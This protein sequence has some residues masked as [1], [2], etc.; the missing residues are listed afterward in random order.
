[1]DAQARGLT[2]EEARERLARCSPNEIRHEPPT[3]PL[4]L[5]AGQ[6]KS[7]AVGLLAAACFVSVILGEIADAVA[8]GTIVILNALGLLSGIPR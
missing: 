5:L 1:M 6:F 8:I 4:V 2:A 3:S 7:P